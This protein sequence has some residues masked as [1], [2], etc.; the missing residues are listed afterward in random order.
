MGKHVLAIEANAE[1]IT[2]K[3][4]FRAHW[5]KGIDER[6]GQGVDTP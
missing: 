5:N 1:L 2:D 6:A 4:Q 3:D